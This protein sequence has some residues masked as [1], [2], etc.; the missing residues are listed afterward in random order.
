MDEGAQV[1][2]KKGETS[3]ARGKKKATEN[4]PIAPTEAWHTLTDLDQ[5]KL[6]ADPLRLRI[7][8]VLCEGERTTKQIADE[9]GERPTKPGTSRGR[10]ADG[11]PCNKPARCC[12][13]L[14]MKRGRGII[15]LCPHSKD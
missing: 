15:P 7:I 8:E 9:I 4:G 5:V 6:L 14:V 1:L 13:H 3:L 12:P 10:W 11:Q 2:D